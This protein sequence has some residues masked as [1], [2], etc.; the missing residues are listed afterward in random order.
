MIE[1]IT[2]YRECVTAGEVV[3]VA[4]GGVVVRVEDGGYVG[5]VDDG[6]LVE[7]YAGNCGDE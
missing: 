4:D 3:R 6:G 2:D 1:T 5:T 7:N